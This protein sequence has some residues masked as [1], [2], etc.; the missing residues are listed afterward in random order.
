MKNTSSRVVEPV[1]RSRSTPV[2]ESETGTPTVTRGDSGTYYASHDMARSG[3]PETIAFALAD[4]TDRDPLDVIGDFSA[5]ADPD[6]LD[7]LF[8]TRPGGEERAEGH[9]TLH[10][11]DHAVTVYSTGTIAIRPLEQ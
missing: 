8:R 4:V 7:R 10:V 9:L 2:A 6:A 11:A 1:P 3:L 5:H